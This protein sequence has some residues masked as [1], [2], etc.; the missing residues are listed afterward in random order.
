LSATAT[1]AGTQ[2]ST[3][4]AT[5]SES[6][7]DTTNNT[8]NLDSTIS[9]PRADLALS[10]TVSPEPAAIGDTLTYQYAL[11]NN[12]PAR[13]SGVT[14]V[15]TLAAGL[16]A[17]A[18]T[19]SQGSCSTQGQTVSCALGVLEAGITAG[20]LADRPSGFW[21]LGDAASSSVAADSSGNGL[22]GVYDPGVVRGQPGAIS[23]DTAASFSGSVTVSVPNAAASG[24]LAGGSGA[25]FIGRLG[26]SLYP[27]QGTLDEVA[28]F[29]VALSVERVRAHYQGGGASL[30]L[31]ATATAAGTQ[32]STAQATASESDP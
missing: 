5:A 25:T 26:Q 9:A 24:P 31:S 22:N 10:G 27:F 30:R 28:V 18:A 11:T 29:P 3:A 13:A 6:D 1:A 21:R 8:V 19:V 32:R 17:G 15:V 23:G 14:L 12:G 2:R 7:P 20:L 4:Q 16:S